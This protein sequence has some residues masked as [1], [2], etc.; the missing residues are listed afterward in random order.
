MANPLSQFLSRL[1]PED[2]RFIRRIGVVALAF[3]AV[4]A[5]ALY[6]LTKGIPE[7][8]VANAENALPVMDMPSIPDFADGSHKVLDSLE[9]DSTNADTAFTTSALEITQGNQILDDFDGQAHLQLMHQKAQEYNYKEAYRH[10][11]RI[12]S[13]LLKNAELSAE[14]GHILLENG[15][16]QESASVLSRI[17]NDPTITTAVKEDYIFALFRSGNTQ[18][19]LDFAD[20]ELKA[21]QTAE[22]LTAKA[23]II[24][25]QPDST[26]RTAADSIF[27]YTLK[28]FPKSPKANYQYG[29]YLMQR[30]D[31]QNSKNYLEKAVQLA[32][33]E[34]RYIARLGM[35][36]FYLKNDS[37]AETLYKKSLALNPYDY[38]TWF[39]LGEL[40]L[41]IANESTY[42]PAIRQ[43]THRALQAYLKAIENDSLHS[44]SHYRVGVI[45][46]GNG[47]QREAIKHLQIAL[48]GTK[49]KIPP[50]QQLST[51]YTALGDTAKSVQYLEEI[52]EI[53]PFNKIAANRL[54]ALG[55]HRVRN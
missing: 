36:E 8:D 49:D 10:A 12:E 26:K 21:A 3:L 29:R 18:A 7:P 20:G 38:N 30:G 22:I 11:E 15:K 46:N 14:W 34:P 6:F 25:E 1:A 44:L 24:G 33:K 13:R 5:V 42:I 16:V 51:S 45:L 31:F 41:S 40:Y 55:A 23:T 32:P 28:K 2:K 47:E 19:A 4:S 17:L 39:N 48:N 27:K 9:V 35:A 54:D 53:D 37:R 50:L 52:L 43:N